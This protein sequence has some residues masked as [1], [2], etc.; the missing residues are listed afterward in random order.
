MTNLNY[1]IIY[2]FLHFERLKVMKLFKNELIDNLH[3]LI[4]KYFSYFNLRSYG[5]VN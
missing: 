1:K 4:P 3:S 2:K 5:Y